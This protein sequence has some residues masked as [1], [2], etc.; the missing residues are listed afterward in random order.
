M[1]EKK[2]KAFFKIIKFYKISIHIFKSYILFLWLHFIKIIFNK[3]T[4]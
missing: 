4:L 2:G 1:H 3:Y